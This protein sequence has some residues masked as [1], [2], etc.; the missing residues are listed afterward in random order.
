MDRRIFI[1]LMALGG[2]PLAQEAYA[3]GTTIEDVLKALGL[4]THDQKTQGTAKSLSAKDADAGLRSALAQGTDAAVNRLAKVDGYW[5][6]PV[7]KIALPGP[8]ATAQRT[9]KPLGAS[10]LLDEVHL[11]MNRAAELAAPIARGLF[12][13]AIKGMTITDAVSIVKGGPTSG[14]DY[15]KKTTSPR[16]TS[17]FIPPMED[18][19]QSTGA[20]SYLSKAIKRN[21]LGAYVKEE[22]KAYLGKYAVGLALDGL[23]HYI[24]VEETA[25]RRDPARRTSQILKTVFG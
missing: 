5:A 20:V 7:V 8:L 9:L 17:L 14:T 1:A 15:L 18:A 11:K 4:N 2:L 12:I 21:R 10:R 19:L 3:K 25:I 16:L 23:F 22:P 6:D 24:G 13:D